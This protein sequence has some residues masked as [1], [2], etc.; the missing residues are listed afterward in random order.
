MRIEGEETGLDEELEGTEN[1]DSNDEESENTEE[2][3]SGN[4]ESEN[5]EEQFSVSIEGEQTPE[6]DEETPK[7]GEAS[8]ITNLRKKNR[9]LEKK[10]KELEKKVVSSEKPKEIKLAPKPNLHDADID[11][12]TEKYEARLSKWYEDKRKVDEQ[13]AKQEEEVKKQQFAWQTKLN[14][15]NESK[16]KLQVKDFKEV[17]DDIASTLSIPQQSIIIK[18]AENPAVLIYALGKNKKT[19]ETLAAITDPVEFTFAVAKLETKL[20]ISSKKPTTTPERILSSS[21]KKSST[22]DNEL[23]KLRAEAE[24]TGNYTK[25]NAYKNKSRQ[26]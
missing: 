6:E 26:K 21:G 8:W 23:E 14:S 4:E 22:F 11:F 5:I 9:E 1:E 7:E 24:K 17:E 16:V 20:K 18:G 19:L 2:Q 12:D 10:A 25:V 3:E 13:A 15:Y